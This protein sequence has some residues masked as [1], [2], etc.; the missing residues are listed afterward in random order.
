[1]DQRFWGRQC[2]ILGVGPTPVHITDFKDVCVEYVDKA[3]EE[4]SE[5]RKNAR[6]VAA[7]IQGKS[8]DGVPENVEAIQ[9]LLVNAKPIEL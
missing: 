5:W 8:E 9:R 3:L 6:E 7:R 2:E 1:M 4:G